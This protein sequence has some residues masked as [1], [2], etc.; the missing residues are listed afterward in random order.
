[1]KYLLAIIIIVSFISACESGRERKVRS[2]REQQEKVESSR[3]AEEL[4]VKEAAE[5]RET[6]RLLAEKEAQKRREQEIHDFYINNSLETG[7]APYRYIYG[8][9]PSC[10][11]YGCSVIKVQT[12][13]NS[14]VLVTIKQNGTVVRHAFIKAG[15]SY[16]FEMP[17][18]TYQPFFYYGRG[19]YPEKE[20]KDTPSGKLKGGFVEREVFGKD[21]PQKLSN[22]ILTYKLILQE[23][24]NFSQKPSNAEEAL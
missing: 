22:N 20:M 9:N 13:D 5:E 12:P 7:V 6:T 1:M 4:R 11:E 24:G 14:D 21:V 19:W 15:D 3:R 10:D 17:D 2:Q 18:G 16:K 8:G 23:N